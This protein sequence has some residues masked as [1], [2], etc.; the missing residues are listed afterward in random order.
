MGRPLTLHSI[1]IF[2][3]SIRK[4]FQYRVAYSLNAVA[5]PSTFRHNGLFD[6]DTA[7]FNKSPFGFSTWLNAANYNEYI[8][9]AAKFKVTFTP[10]HQIVGAPSITNYLPSPAGLMCICT[11]CKLQDMSTPT[12][13]FNGNPIDSNYS[14]VGE[15]KI[16]KRFADSNTGGIMKIKK[17]ITTKSTLGGKGWNPANEV[18]WYAPWNGLPQNSTWIHFYI[19]TA[20]ANENLHGI[21]YFE[22]KYYVEMRQ[23][24]NIAIAPEDFKPDPDPDAPP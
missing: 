23:N 12:N 1:K 11:Q 14:K 21:L 10:T 17:Y 20:E 9:R 13:P 7:I 18:D 16:A 22:I 15:N 2:P 3:K 19:Q 24:L 4:T 6:P 5:F 8:V